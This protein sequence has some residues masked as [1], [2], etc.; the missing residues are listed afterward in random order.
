MSES[1]DGLLA[2]AEGGR[3][4]LIRAS[5]VVGPMAAIFVEDGVCV[6]VCVCV[7]VCVCMQVRAC[8]HACVCM[9]E[10]MCVHACVCVSV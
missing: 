4:A 1:G 5:A 6:R 9:C 7:C 8:V 3:P 2:I 10:C